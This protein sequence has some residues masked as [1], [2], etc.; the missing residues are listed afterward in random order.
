M[1]PGETPTP[2][3]VAKARERMKLTQQEAAALIFKKWRAWDRY[4]KGLRKMDPAYW[5]LWLI[6]AKIAQLEENG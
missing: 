1:K 2:E 5:E 4:E 6:K 3:Q